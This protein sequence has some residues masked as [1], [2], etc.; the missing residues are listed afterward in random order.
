MAYS[1]YP[2]Q[3]FPNQVLF[4]DTHLHTT[5]SADAG[6]VGAKLTPDDAYRYARGEVV[7]SNTGL[8][9]RLARPLDFLVVTDHAENLGLPYA[10]ETKTR[11]LLDPVGAGD[12]REAP[13]RAAIEGMIAGYEFW[14]Q[15]VFAGEDPLAGHR[16]CARPCGNRP[17]RPPRANNPP[18]PS[19]AMIGFEWT[20]QPDGANMHR[21]VIYP[22]RQGDSRSVM[23]ISAYDTDD[24][25]R[26]WDWMERL[27]GRDGRTGPRH[28]AQRQP[29]ERADVR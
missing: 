24:P 5:F 18:A 4:G 21:N 13:R 1:P 7:T 19:R 23:P 29:F 14:M 16:L 6:L 11:S 22:G 15:A 25:E 26:L 8:Q 12:H 28:P 2:E 9:A 20:S 27:R 3:D 17:P 10:M